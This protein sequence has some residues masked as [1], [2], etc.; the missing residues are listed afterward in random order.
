MLSYKKFELLFALVLIVVEVVKSDDKNFSLEVN[1]DVKRFIKDILDAKSEEQLMSGRFGKSLPDEEDIDNEVE[2]EY[3]N[4]YDDETESQGII[5][6]R[7][8]RQLLRGRFGRQNDNNAASKE[9]QW[10]GGRFGKEV[11][12][13]WF[14]GR[15]GREI[16]GRFLPRFAREFNKPHYR[17][18]FGRIAKL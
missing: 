14:N 7:Y 5:N 1:K 12:T 3:D 8:G 6:G 2:N 4:E 9:N 11:A 15:F 17:G 13:Q 18:R 16:G 10:L